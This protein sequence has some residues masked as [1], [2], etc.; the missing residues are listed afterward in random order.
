[1]TTDRYDSICRSIDSMAEGKAVAICVVCSTKVTAVIV[2]LALPDTWHLVEEC[3]AFVWQACNHRV[4]I[5]EAQRLSEALESTPEWQCEDNAH[6]PFVVTRA[7]DFVSFAL[8]AVASPPCAKEEAKKALSLLVEF[9][10]G[11]D[12]SARAFPSNPL[13]ANLQASEE[14]SQERLVKMLESA[15]AASSEGVAALRQ[16]ADD[17]AELFKALLPI[18]CYDYVSS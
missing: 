6:L 1:M 10:E 4:D 7:L 2:R 3:L 16:E 14:A 9:A 15:S 11:F 13:D 5:A 8:L 12:S 17:I 18:Y